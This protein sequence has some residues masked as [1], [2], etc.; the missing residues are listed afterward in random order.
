[1][2][3]D[4]FILLNRVFTRNTLREVLESNYSDEYAYRDP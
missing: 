4:N 1:M 3:Q 2:S